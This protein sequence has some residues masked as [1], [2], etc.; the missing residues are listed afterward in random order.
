MRKKKISLLVLT[1]ILF[2]YFSAFFIINAAGADYTLDIN[3][4][5]I[6]IWKVEKL[7]QDTYESIFF[8]EKPGFDEDDSKKIQITDIDKKT[9]YWRIIY[10]LWDY[11]DDTEDFSNDADDERSKKIY[12]DPED[13]VDDVFSDADPMGT[14]ADM[15]V[16]PTPFINYIEE[17]RDEFD[18]PVITVYVDDSSLIAKYGVVTAE[19]EIELT[20]GTNG[21]LEKLE[22]IDIHGDV[23]VEIVLQKEAIPGYDVVL[24]YGIIII[25]AIISVIVWKK[26]L[27][28]SG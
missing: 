3:E 19:Y 12:K 20:Y 13:K 21:I 11:T 25:C 28:Y 5:D 8:P 2:N 17:F 4:N 27:V 22:Y 15:W 7:D 18:H 14:I 23:F 24:F 6:F 16:V 10:Y 9:D 26:K 1:L